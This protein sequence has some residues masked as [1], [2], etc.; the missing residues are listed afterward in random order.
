M[1]KLY[2]EKRTSKINGVGLFATKA[3]KKGETVGYIDGPVEVIKEFTPTLSKNTL[4]WIGVGKKSW[5]NTNNSPFRFINHSCEPNVAHV[6]KR[7]VVAVKN[8]ALGEEMTFDYSLSEAED[9]WVIAGC[10]CNTQTC[11]GTIMSITH[12][13]KKIFNRKLNHIPKKF[14]QIYLSANT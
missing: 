3:F 14:Q 4:N 11:R 12:L 10:R 6:A 9:G 2:A 5:I 7:K 1:K 13:P 8:I